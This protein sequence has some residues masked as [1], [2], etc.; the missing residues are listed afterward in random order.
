M[1]NHQPQT[2]DCPFCIFAN[3]G[4]TSYNKRSDIVFEDDNSVAFIS[5]KWWPNNPGH[6]IIIPKKHVENIYD[7]QD[8]ILSHV[9]ITAKQI[10]I[11]L[12]ETYKCSGTSMRQHNEPAGNQDMW[13]FHIHVFPRYEND[14]LYVEQENSRMVTE[15]ERKPYADKLRAYFGSKK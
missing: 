6:V 5:P 4:E 9:Y 13:H 12:K 2:Y 15:E 11:A 8:D 1:Y 7:I 10:A 3:G 14:E